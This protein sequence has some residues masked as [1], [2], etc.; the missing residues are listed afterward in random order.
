MLNISKE[1]LLNNNNRNNETESFAHFTYNK[2]LYNAKFSSKLS[3]PGFFGR[4]I[5]NENFFCY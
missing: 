2:N 3:V 1:N 4:S 5:Y